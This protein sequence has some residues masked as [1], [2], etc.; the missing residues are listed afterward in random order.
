MSCY[1][2]IFAPLSKKA[3]AVNHCSVKTYKPPIKIVSDSSL[4]GVDSSL[5]VG[6]FSFGSLVSASAVSKPI[7]HI[8]ATEYKT[9]TSTPMVYGSG[10]NIL[11]FGSLSVKHL[12]KKQRWW[13]W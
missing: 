1:L 13:V 8:K 12:S 11:S 10:K 3:P 6:S 5:K 7:F 2:R 4:L 9:N